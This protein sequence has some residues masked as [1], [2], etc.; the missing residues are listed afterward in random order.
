MPQR[1][2]RG[3]LVT[4]STPTRKDQGRA[5]RALPAASQKRRVLGGAPAAASRVG[6]LIAHAE[7][8]VASER[9]S[10][11]E[12][13]KRARDAATKSII[14]HRA[15]LVRAS[16]R[17]EASDFEACIHRDGGAFLRVIGRGKSGSLRRHAI[18]CFAAAWEDC[19]AFELSPTARNLRFRGAIFETVV[20]FCAEAGLTGTTNELVALLKMALRAAPEARFCLEGALR[21]PRPA[22][23]E[24]GLDTSRMTDSQAEALRRFMSRPS[25]APVIEAGWTPPTVPPQDSPSDASE[26]AQALSH[27]PDPQSPSARQPAASTTASA[28]RLQEPR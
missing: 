25:S 27:R 8:L 28:T 4:T 6:L 26:P 5:S 10:D 21:L 11:D 24:A 14:R 19:C 2:K 3:R 17:Q 22:P 13:R 7:K 20:G 1:M 9:S 16:D 12:S 15:R 18:A 23:F